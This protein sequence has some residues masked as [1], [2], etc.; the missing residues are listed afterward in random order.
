MPSNRCSCNNI[1]VRAL[2][3]SSGVRRDVPCG[4]WSCPVCNPLL[5]HIQRERIRKNIYKWERIRMATF[6][7]S[8]FRSVPDEDF[9]DRDGN[10]IETDKTLY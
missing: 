3:L 2:D 1:Y 5:V 9:K 8:Y 6:G 4:L 10:L 7:L